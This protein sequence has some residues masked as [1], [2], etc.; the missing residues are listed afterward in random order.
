MTFEVSQIRSNLLTAA[1]IQCHL[2]QILCNSIKEL[3][4]GSG[5]QADR[6]NPFSL[7]IQKIVRGREVWAMVPI[8]HWA[9]LLQADDIVGVFVSTY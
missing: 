3:F 9:S 1:D 5:L 8:N 6:L 7:R 4:H 2:A